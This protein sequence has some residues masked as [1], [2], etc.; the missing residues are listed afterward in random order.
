MARL[1]SRRLMMSRIAGTICMGSPAVRMVNQ[2]F[3]PLATYMVGLISRRSPSY[4]VL[5]TTPTTSQPGPRGRVLSSVIASSTCLPSGF[6]LGKK[7]RAK[8]SLMMT[9]MGAA[10]GSGGESGGRAERNEAAEKSAPEKVAACQQRNAQGLKE[11]GS[12]GHKVRIHAFTLGRSGYMDVRVPFAA[13]QQGHPRVA[14]G[15][16][17][18]NCR[19]LFLQIPI[20]RIKLRAFVACKGGIEAKDQNVVGIKAKI[21]LLEVSQCTH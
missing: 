15:S 20:E 21:Y 4:L 11:P 5:P 10:A 1:L 13:G 19:K 14:D 2:P 12:H 18:R 6:I 3:P 17:T 8:V 9:G 7:R 16:H